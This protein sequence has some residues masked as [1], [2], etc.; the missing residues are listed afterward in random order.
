MGRHVWQSHGVSA[1][2]F[3]GHFYRTTEGCSM[4]NSPYLW[5]WPL[6]AFPSPTPPSN[7]QSTFSPKR[8]TR[9]LVAPRATTLEH[10]GGVAV[11]TWSPRA[12]S[13]EKVQ[14]RSGEAQNSRCRCSFGFFWDG[15][16]VKGSQATRICRM[17]PV[18]VYRVYRAYLCTPVFLP[19]SLVQCSCLMPGTCDT[20]TPGPL[21]A[22]DQQFFD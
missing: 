9:R 19:P 4:V 21:R 11:A 6:W 22:G 7:H 13:A 18:G 16:C 20:C 14:R 8:F 2:G 10:S 17:G 12:G 1:E 3:F 5:P 15:R